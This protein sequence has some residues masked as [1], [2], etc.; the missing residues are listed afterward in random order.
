MAMSLQGHM[1][2]LS[3]SSAANELAMEMRVLK[4][5][6]ATD[7][8]IDHTV[9]QGCDGLVVAAHCTMDGLPDQ[10]KLYAVKMLY[11]FAE[12]ERSKRVRNMFRNEWELLAQRSHPNVVHL[13]AEFSDVITDPFY[14]LI[15]PEIRELAVIQ[16]GPRRGNRCKAQFV[17]LDHHMHDLEA[18]RSSYPTPLPV[19]DAKR[20]AGDLLEAACFLKK[21]RIA[22]L[23]LKLNNIVVAE[24]GR[25]VLIDFGYAKRFSSRDMKVRFEPG[26]SIG[27]NQLHLAPEILQRYGDFSR[28]EIRPGEQE[29]MQ[30]DYSG[31]LAWAVGVL[32][33]E[34]ITGEHPLPN[35]PNQYIG[36]NKQLYR[37][38]QIA[39]LPTF[40]PSAFQAIVCR[41]LH[42]SPDLRATI[43]Q[44]IRVIVN[45][46]DTRSDADA[47]LEQFRE[48]HDQTRATVVAA[49]T[50]TQ[51]A[52]ENLTARVEQYEHLVQQQQQVQQQQLETITSLTA[53]IEQYEEQQQKHEQQQQQ[54]QEKQWGTIASLMS[55]VVLD[56]HHYGCV[57]GPLH[58]KSWKIS[59]IETANRF[60][61]VKSC[62]SRLFHLFHFCYL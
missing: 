24:D 35:Y 57:A 36:P 26:M 31:Q 11:T 34:L 55:R 62:L 54:V 39:K 32:T 20:F 27:G 2:S 61:L 17:V 37:V 49:N 4:R 50:E 12:F 42:P 33:H 30:L 7:F 38:E 58:E 5:T 29:N 51:A 10:G 15:S 59:H 14:N 52:I 16:N 23:D 21:N 18:H 43:D 1:S 22:H 48:E 47:L 9:E 45:I 41:L 3:L 60:Y 28:R 19:G 46:R 44:G 56:R 13:W 40:Y 8:L 6:R 25:L 53:R